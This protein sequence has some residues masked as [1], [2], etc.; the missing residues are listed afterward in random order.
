MIKEI[1]FEIA[2]MS[3]MPYNPLQLAK[4]LESNQNTH[5]I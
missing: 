5:K 1:T 4:K 2:K 3:R